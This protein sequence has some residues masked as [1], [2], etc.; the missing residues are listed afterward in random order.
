VVRVVQR[1]MD[2]YSKVTTIEDGWRPTTGFVANSICSMACLRGQEASPME[3]ADGQLTPALP[4]LGLCLAEP[5]SPQ[6][7]DVRFRVRQPRFQWSRKYEWRVVRHGIDL[8]PVVELWR[9]KSPLG[10]R[11]SARGIRAKADRLGVHAAS[12]GVRTQQRANGP[13]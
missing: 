2:A 11:F 7:Q 1:S 12:V 3:I 5:A 8:Q 6:R 10:P 13:H 4:C 9:A